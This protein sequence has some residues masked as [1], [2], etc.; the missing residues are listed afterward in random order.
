MKITP[1]QLKQLIKEEIIKEFDSD[2]F[3]SG[4]DYLIALAVYEGVDEIHLY[5]VCMSKKSEYAHQKPSVEHWI[6]IAKGRGVK[7]RVHGKNTAILRTKNY[8]MY[9]YQ[10]PQA[11]VE[12]HHPGTITELDLME[13]YG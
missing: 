11:F 7:V 3:G 2:Y 13:K 9:G 6:G 5:G 8:L 12:K 4:I 1:G 10:K